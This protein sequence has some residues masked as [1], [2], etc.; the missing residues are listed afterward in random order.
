MRRL[1]AVVFD[2]DGVL[3]DCRRGLL[4]PDAVSFIRALPRDVPIAIASGATNAEILGILQQD[5]LAAAFTAI[6]GIDQTARSK[7]YPDPYLAAL[8][9]MSA[10]GH[11]IDAA[12]SVAIDDSLS[13]LVSARSAGM[14]C[15]GVAQRGSEA[16]LAPHAD[17]IVASLAALTLDA[18]DNLVREV[19]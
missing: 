5:D 8:D 18:L 15:V 4:L 2:F 13:G 6:V 3:A 16:R 1:T 11:P 7:P 10:A 14:R 17:L 12:A 19:R 9:R